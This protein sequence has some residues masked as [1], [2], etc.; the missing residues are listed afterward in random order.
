MHR[1]LRDQVSTN[2]HTQTHCTQSYEFIYVEWHRESAGGSKQYI[3]KQTQMRESRTQMRESRSPFMS[4]NIIVNLLL[5]GILR[6]RFFSSPSL[7]IRR[8]GEQF[9]VLLLLFSTL[10]S[11]D[12]CVCV[13]WVLVGC[14]C[15]R[16]RHR[17]LLHL[18]S[19]FSSHRL[20]CKKIQELLH[21]CNSRRD[22]N[23]QHGPIS[24]DA[25]LCVYA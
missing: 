13:Y 11:V 16:R 23:T 14:C 20:L 9:Y 1:W 18:K 25:W 7:P 21:R 24:S 2:K 6:V 12:S 17:G 8:I 22:A 3:Y 5:T 4:N 15:R 10:C 19:S